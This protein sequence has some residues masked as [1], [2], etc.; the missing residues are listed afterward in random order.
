[1]VGAD[2]K[3]GLVKINP[4]LTWTQARRLG[5]YRHP[6]VPYNP[7][8]D[9]GYASIGCWPC[10]RPW[11]S[12]KMSGRAAGPATPRRNVGCTRST[13]ASFEKPSTRMCRTGMVRCPMKI[14]AKAEYACLAVLALARQSA[15]VVIRAYSR[16]FP[17]V[18][19]TRT[20]PGADLL[21]LKGAGLVASTRGAAGGYRLAR[22]ASS[23]SLTEIL[24]AVDG[25]DKAQRGSSGDEP[26]GRLGPRPC[27]GKRSGRGT[28]GARP[29]H[30]RPAR[31]AV[32]RP[33]NGSFETAGE[34]AVS[35]RLAFDR[36]SKGDQPFIRR[37]STPIRC[38]RDTS[39]RRGLEH[40]VWRDARRSD[41]Q[42][43]TSRRDEGDRQRLCQPDARR[44]RPVRSRAA[45]RGWLLAAQE[46]F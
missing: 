38:D 36:I 9:Q 39:A 27:M 43:R 19:D 37:S 21:Q 46:A 22:P 18:W 2:P 15:R 44:A 45:R 35:S 33:T 8:H 1:M 34:S 11:P 14:S 41:R 7:L 12:G 26:A 4:L 13:A 32:V 28:R 16:D 31:R 42:R 10:T 40:S 25:P 23:I 3:F 24:I 17:G 20:I 5:L 6:N 29:H 30:D